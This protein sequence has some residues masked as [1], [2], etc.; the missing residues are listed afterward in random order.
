[1]RLRVIWTMLC[2][3][4]VSQVAAAQVAN[5]YAVKC[6][7]GESDGKVLAAGSYRTAINVHNPGPGAAEFRYKVAL[8]FPV[9]GRISA[10]VSQ[11]LKPDAALEIDCPD[12]AKALGATNPPFFK[13]FVVIQSPIPLDVV[14][15]YTAGPHNQIQTMEMERV[16]ARQTKGGGQTAVCPDLVV[17]SINLPTWDPTLRRSIITAV[18][19]NVGTAPAAPSAARV[20]DLLTSTGG[21]A[22]AAT[23]ALNPGISC[24]V[25]FTLPY[26]VFH[27]DAKLRVYADINHVVPE[28]D[29]TNNFRDF[30]LVG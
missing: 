25:T 8:G 18:I 28:C 24:T 3:I 6:M 14:A 21:T 5:E 13:G 7:C 27:P 16:A 22:T 1:M 2:A 26:W 12:A 20:Q 29:E 10:F 23:P 15:V 4:V 19:R 11:T 17:E 30:E 9:A